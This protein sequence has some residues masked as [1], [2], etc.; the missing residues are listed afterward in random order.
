VSGGI[1]AIRR[2]DMPELPTD[3]ILDDMWVPLRA[4]F[5]RKGRIALSEHALAFDT[6]F[7]DGRE[8][9][10]KARTL[11][12]NFQLLARTPSLL[13]PI[14]NPVWFQLVSHKLMRLVC[15]VALAALFVS[16][17]M[18]AAATGP[19][20]GG[21]RALFGGQVVF[22]GLASLGGWAGT[23]GRIA[24]TFVVLNAA[25]ATGFWRFL[26]RSQ[27]IVW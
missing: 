1:Y 23:A 16:T 22:Y 11:A 18:L 20:G 9:Q 8:F 27:S 2:E 17:A 14:D 12:G 7:E 13:W 5:E 25:A 15:P 26:R 10:R 24:R 21:W 3:V 4:S 6:A 19:E